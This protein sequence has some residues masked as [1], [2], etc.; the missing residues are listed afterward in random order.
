V[1]LRFY[2]TEKNMVQKGKEGYPLI[3]QKGNQIKD[4]E[5]ALSA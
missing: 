5:V 4:L 2:I 3:C 1:S